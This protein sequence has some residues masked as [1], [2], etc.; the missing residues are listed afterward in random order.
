MVFLG[1][2]IGLGTI[3]SWLGVLSD[4]ATYRRY[5]HPRD[6][7]ALL[8]YGVLENLVYRQWKAYVAW[9]GLIRYLRGDTSWGE[10]TW[11][12]FDQDTE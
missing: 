7:V 9:R 12:G 8:A 3:L 5:D 6:V 11:I 10:M 2:A 1:I 4:V